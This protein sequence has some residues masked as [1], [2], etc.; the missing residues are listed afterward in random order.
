M[1]KTQIINLHEDVMKAS[2][3]E[4]DNR[5]TSWMK[6]IDSVDTTKSNGYALVGDFINNRTI[7]ITPADKPRLILAMAVSG[8]RNYNHKYFAV[9][10]LNP[11]GS[12][13]NT[14]I[15]TDTCDDYSWALRIRD[16]VAALIDEI[17]GGTSMSVPEQVSREIVDALAPQVGIS[18]DGIAIV[19]AILAKYI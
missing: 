2:G 13:E 9:M 3:L 10:Q 1:A 4:I 19:A 8:S 12:L 16:D 5:F 18:D 15:E 7:E 17:A 14:G 6:W 11:D